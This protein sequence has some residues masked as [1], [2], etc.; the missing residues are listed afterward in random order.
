MLE[1][2]RDMYLWILRN[3]HPLE[4]IFMLFFWF[5]YINFAIYC[6]QDKTAYEICLTFPIHKLANSITKKLELI[7]PFSCGVEKNYG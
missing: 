4:K 2:K 6:K 1:M 3:R 7:V 5:I